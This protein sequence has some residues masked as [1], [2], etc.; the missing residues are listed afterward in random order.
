MGKGNRKTHKYACDFETTVY[1]GQKSSEV[2]SAAMTEINGPDESVLTFSSIDEYL[3]YIF[4]NHTHRRQIYYFHNLKFDGEFI[5]YWLMSNGYKADY[6]QTRK[7]MNMKNDSY[8]TVISNMNQW[9]MIN[10]KV[11]GRLYIF[12]DSL[13]LLPF[14]LSQIGKSFK[15]KHQK[16]SMVYEGERR[17]GYIPDDDELEY[18]KNDVL[19]LREALEKMFEQGFSGLTIG[20]CCMDNFKKLFFGIK[21]F[22][23]SFPNL[24]EIVIEETFGDI[25]ADAYIRRGYRGGWCY[26]MFPGYEC[27]NG[28]VY[29]VNSLYPSVMHSK[30]GAYYPVGLPHFWSGNYIPKC[31]LTNTGYNREWYF[32]IRFECSFKIRP[33]K[34]PFVSIKDSIYYKATEM[35][36][37]SQIYDKYHTPIRVFDRV[38]GEFKENTVTLTMSCIDFRLFLE[39]YKVD[40]FKILDGVYFMAVEGLFD[41]YI[42]HYMKMKIEATKDNDPV[43]RQLSK[44]SL[45]N[46]YGKFAAN[47]DSSYKECYIDPE[48][49][50]TEFIDIEAHDKTPGFIAVGAAVTSWARDFTIRAAQKNYKS[51]RYADT[52]SL[53]LELNDND[54]V[55]GIEEDDTALCCWKMENEFS[56]ALFVRAKTYIEY[57][58]EKDDYTIKCAG[59]PQHC[60]NLFEATIRYNTYDERLKWLEKKKETIQGLTEKEKEF[61]SHKHFIED[62]SSNFKIPGKLL[63]VHVPGGVLLK[64]VDF[65]VR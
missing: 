50:C 49:E 14:T 63:P 16:T 60:K 8:N 40:N 15:T 5:V 41:D 45:N 33:N 27:K 23:N 43:R 47:S 61:L 35:L 28:R 62:L 31:L 42:D 53:H 55:F 24:E 9:Y 21:K 52:D 4:N 11:N 64:K 32:Y 12:R 44:L 26:T 17:P 25:N 30:S 20:S 19:V 37:S 6:T 65:T 18:I 59:L 57:N 51:F 7:P 38:T 36:T 22:K 1:H 48:T 34:L 13:K 10:I 29:D 58:E 2:W 3:D 54:E 46:L 56:R 39:H